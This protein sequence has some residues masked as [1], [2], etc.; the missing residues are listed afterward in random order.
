MPISVQ[1]IGVAGGFGCGVDA[2]RRALSSGST[3]PSLY[4]IVH[5]GAP[6]ELPAHRADTERLQDF[7][8]LRALRR[9]DRFSRLGMLGAYLALEDAG[10]LSAGPHEGLGVI[11]ATGLGPTGI[12]FAFEDTFLT[13]GDICASPTYFAN[14]VHNSVAA[15]I[16]LLLGAT[17]P[18][19]TV[20]Q[21]QLSVPAAL[22]TAWLWLEEG[23]VDRVLFGAVDEL[24]ELVAYAF[25]RRYGIPPEGRM[26]PLMTGTDSAVIGEGAA[27]FLLSR[28]EETQPGYCRLERVDTGR[29]LKPRAPGDP[30]ELWVIGADGRREFG[31]GYAAWAAGTEFACFTPHY[32]SSPVG[33]AFDL[34]AAALMLKTGSVFPTPTSSECGFSARL[35]EGGSVLSARR[36]ACLSLGEDEGFGLIR[37]KKR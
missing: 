29:R 32:G 37:L 15:N 13:A 30:A 9:V 33:P 21:F 25:F 31:A 23:R 12:I 11:I 36:I 20:S 19:S 14:S 8:P 3:Q 6:L 35:A 22:Q 24:S 28:K 17:G 27:F 2:F 16:S 26:T 18:N 10:L 1:G 34:A 5:A 7:V 4:P